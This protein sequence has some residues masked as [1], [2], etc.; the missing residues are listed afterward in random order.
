MAVEE[1]TVIKN[2]H[3]GNE[4]WRYAGWIIKESNKGLLVEA[5]FNRSDMEFNGILL[6]EGDRFLELYPYGKWFNIF[7]VHDRDNGELKAWYCNVIRPVITRNG[8][9]IYDDLALDLLVFPNGKHLTL[10]YDEFIGLGLDPKEASSALAGLEELKD[11]FDL[12]N[13]L[14]ICEMI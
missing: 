14:N 10:D 7:E 3:R 2:D 8:Y 12:P 5:Y 4:T 1:I 9:V 6:R 11:I 13:Q